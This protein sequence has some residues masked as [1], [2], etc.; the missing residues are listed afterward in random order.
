MLISIRSL[1]IECMKYGFEMKMIDIKILSLL[2]KDSRK[3][4]TK[5]SKLCKVS[6]QSVSNRVKTMKRDGIIRRFTVQVDPY[7]LG[8]K[9]KAIIQIPLK[10]RGLSEELQN[11]LMNDSRITWC[12]RSYEG[13]LFVE[14]MVIEQEELNEL[15]RTIETA[16]SIDKLKVFLV[17]KEIKND[18]LHPIER[19]LK[20]KEKFFKI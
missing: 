16:F 4:F 14:A 5:I 7:K 9:L 13:L 15:L 12:Y 17:R 2:I 1:L 18:P 19:L 20:L 6:R 10:K 11:L 3:E 8:I